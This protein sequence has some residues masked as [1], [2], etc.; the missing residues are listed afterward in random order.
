MQ[1][2]LVTVDVLTILGSAENPLAV[3]LYGNA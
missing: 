3:V 1:R 2:E